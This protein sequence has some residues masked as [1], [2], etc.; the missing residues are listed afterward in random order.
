MEISATTL[1]AVSTVIALLMA[2]WSLWQ[3]Y[4]VNGRLTPSAILKALGQL[5]GA[6]RQMYDDAVI[7]VQYVEQI[8]KPGAPGAE[9]TNAQKKA[10]AMRVLK[11]RWPNANVEEIDQAI[12][13]AVFAVKALGLK[14][15]EVRVVA[16]GD[17]ELDGR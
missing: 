2:A 16:S 7:A 17:A 1:L 10:E 15:P 12:E 8:S 9:L 3:I 6:A 13:A 4:Q 14:L 5:P 11:R